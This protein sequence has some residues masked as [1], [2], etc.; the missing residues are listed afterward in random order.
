MRY[1]DPSQPNLHYCDWIRAWTDLGLRTYARIAT[2]NPSFLDR[3]DS[4]VRQPVNV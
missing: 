2:E 4:A 3:F 1:S